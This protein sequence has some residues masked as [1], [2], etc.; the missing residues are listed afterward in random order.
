MFIFYMKLYRFILELNFSIV[1]LNYYWMNYLKLNLRKKY[2]R[3]GKDKFNP[4]NIGVSPQ[5]DKISGVFNL[6]HIFNYT[7]DKVN[8]SILSFW[9][10]PSLGMVKLRISWGPD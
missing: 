3:M 6:F 2:F 1:N 8:S 9:S 7:E 5:H 4:L 10:G